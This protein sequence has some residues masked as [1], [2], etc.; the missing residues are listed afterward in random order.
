L[1]HLQCHFGRCEPIGGNRSA[2]L[3]GL[4]QLVQEEF[5]RL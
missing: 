3:L 1:I 4:A 5:C 2:I